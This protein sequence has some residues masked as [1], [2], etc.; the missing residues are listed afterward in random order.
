M[1]LW[2]VSRSSLSEMKIAITGANGFLGARLAEILLEDH[3]CRDL[4][5]IS[6]RG[7][8]SGGHAVV[9][10]LDAAAVRRAVQ[11]RDAVV[12]CAFDFQDLEANLRIASILAEIC[13]EH[14]VRLVHISTAAVHEP[15]PDGELDEGHVPPSGG[16]M[17]QQVKLATENELIRYCN[18]YGLELIILRPTIVYGP[19][20]RAWTDSPIRELL[21]GTVVLPDEGN[22]LCNAVFVDDVCH[23]IIAGLTATSGTGKTILISGAKP[24]TWN[25]FYSAYQS[26]L[27]VGSLCLSSALSVRPRQVN[28]EVAAKGRLNAAKGLV[29]KFLGGGRIVRL[30]SLA[31][32]LLVFI[33]GP[34]VHLAAGA[35]LALFSSH[36]HV[37]IDTA[38][39]LLGYEPRFDLRQ[40]MER[41]ASYVRKRYR[42][43]SRISRLRLAPGLKRLEPL[44]PLAMPAVREVPRAD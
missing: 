39:Q 33:R 16:T 12:H 38:K 42:F 14:G 11:D 24:V 43:V 30:R 20:G 3:A 1:E 28:S 25:E 26:M 22:G 7:R 4:R 34:K 27:G 29:I 37:R 2:C 10:L 13:V 19:F 44:G 41:T 23:A 31:D 9:D 32:C 18:D 8:Q 5:M 6:R 15:L 17:Y 35:K 40:G 36:C 21:T